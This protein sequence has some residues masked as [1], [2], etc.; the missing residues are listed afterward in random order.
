MLMACGPDAHGSSLNFTANPV[1]LVML[2]EKPIGLG[3]GFG[4]TLWKVQKNMLGAVGS[5]PE[6]P[7]VFGEGH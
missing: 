6:P 1:G 3:F 5:P 7:K 2:N 4:L